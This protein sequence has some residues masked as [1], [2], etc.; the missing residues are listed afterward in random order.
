MNEKKKKILL[1]E[2]EAL[3]AMAETQ[4]LEMM[5]YCVHRAMSG[6]DAVKAALDTDSHFDLILMDIDLGDGIDGTQAA[7]QIVNKK[8]IPVVFLSAHTDP[9]TVEKTER[10]TSYGYVVKNSGATVLHASINMAFRLHEAYCRYNTRNQELYAL[11]EQ[12]EQANQELTCTE[13][14]LRNRE[15]SLAES[16]G[17]FRSVLELVPDMISIHDPNMNILYSNWRSFAQVPEVKRRIQTKC[18]KTYRDL[19]EICSDCLAKTVLETGEPLQREAELPE[20][21]WVD[22]RA[23]P[24][25][26]EQNN[27][28]MFVEWVRD[29]T[30]EK[31]KQKRLERSEEEF[32]RLFETMS[33]GVVYHSADGTIVAANPAAERILG[34]TVDQM[35]GKTTMDPRWKM[36]DDAGNDV[37]GSEH[38]AMITLRT[39]ETVGPVDRAVFVPERDEYVWLSIT[40]IPLFYPGDDHPHQVYATFENITERKRAE[41]ALRENTNAAHQ[42]F[43]ESAAGAFF[44]MLDEPIEWNDAVDKE[45]VL[46]YVFDHQRITK[47]ND[48][49]LDQYRARADDFLGKTPNQLFA[50][51]V[52]HGR[53]LWRKMLDQGFL[54]IDSD[55]RTF[56]GSPLWIVGSYRCMYDK[57]G[58]IVGHFGTQH[59]LTEL[60]QAEEAVKAKSNLLERIFDNNIDLIALTDLHGN[61]QM[62]GNAHRIL[63]Y[64][65]AS[66]IGRNVLDFVHPEDVSFVGD[67]FRTFVQTGHVRSV[68]YRYRRID[69]EYLWFETT[70]TILKDKNGTPEQILFNTRDITER[71]RAEEEIQRQLSEKETLL[72]EAHHRIKNSV[73]SIEGLL[74]V[75]AMSTEHADVRLALQE[76]VSRVKSIR[77][78]YEKLLIGNDSQEVSARDYIGSLVD[79][80]IAVFPERTDVTIEQKIGDF[81]LSSEDAVSVGIIMNELLTNVFKHAFKGRA[82]GRVVIQLDKL[83]NQ[84]TLTVHD[85]GVGS[86]TN[87]GADTAPGFGLTL[88]KML[89][90]QLNGSYTVE[91]DSGTKSV[92]KYCC[93]QGEV[94]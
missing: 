6:E 25:L 57:Q 53:S 55:E 11:A 93:P 84:V 23:I 2:D 20:G 87:V 18:Y 36:V 60:K 8:D 41:E 56:D 35:S 32:R 44:M 24:V 51:D 14:E 92:V 72:R 88:V 47:V 62:A 43:S 63:G 58:R 86:D 80:L 31:E 89:A 30:E 1:V 19:N 70:G 74:S 3:I 79:S 77:V 52:E 42:F 66:L 38:P 15:T 29:I 94:S 69:G 5:G 12:L 39:G 83:E 85:N 65:I 78:L 68:E 54:S 4:Q 17:R 61:Y 50:H 22:V 27:V 67:Q 34:L 48:A 71:K 16:D 9:E 46:D 90:E 28:T 26:D 10:I 75:Q 33:P 73:A 91:D 37:P 59:D 64:E 49:M 40:A 76:A 7:E 45:H 13:E 81:A 82:E 21:K